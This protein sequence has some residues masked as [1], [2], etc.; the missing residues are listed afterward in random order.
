MTISNSSVALSGSRVIAIMAY[1][2]RPKTGTEHS[3][4]TREKLDSQ[5][6]AATDPLNKASAQLAR[7]M[8]ESMGKQSVPFEEARAFAAGV[9]N[10]ALALDVNGDEFL[11]NA[12]QTKASGFEKNL[13]ADAAASNHARIFGDVMEARKPL[14]EFLL[15]RVNSGKISAGS[16][17]GKNVPES[18]FANLPGNVR[19]D[20]NRFAR[21][22]KG[23]GYGYPSVGV[24]KVNESL[25]VYAVNGIVS[26]TG[27]ETHFYTMSGH[28]IIGIYAGQGGGPDPFI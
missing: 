1:A 12:E 25:S 13:L 20:F 28:Y 19:A 16:P 24:V 6:S 2:T 10:R 21:T 17:T 4:V 27:D 8:F 5:V 11:T 7:T 15:P 14:K 9:M 26:D 23:Y 18:Q 22:S 3:E